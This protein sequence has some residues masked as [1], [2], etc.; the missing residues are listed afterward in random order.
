MGSPSLSSLKLWDT[1]LKPDPLEKGNLIQTI[2]GP[3]NVMVVSGLAALVESLD[4]NVRVL[5]KGT[6]TLGCLERVKEIVKPD[7]VVADQV[8]KKQVVTRDGIVVDATDIRFHYR[9]NRS[10]LGLE[11]AI[12]RRVY[13]LS[14]DA[15]GEADWGA[16]VKGAVTSPITSLIANNLL[17]YLTASGFQKNN[18][19]TPVPGRPEPRKTDPRSE[20]IKQVN[21]KGKSALTELGAELLWCDIG[22]FELPREVNAKRAET[23][24]KTWEGKMEIMRAKKEV[25][26]MRYRRAYA[27]GRTEAQIDLL[28]KIVKGLDG[29][30][31]KGPLPPNSSNIFMTGVTHLLDTLGKDA[32]DERENSAGE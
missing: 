5:E 4:G 14:L 20:I 7:E 1:S 23:W 32:L 29:L 30:S 19:A 15:K 24:Q 25:A 3:G 31:N 2:G 13:N 6:H 18:V 17:N 22:H 16:S 26:R 10:E 28:I 12:K 27:L 11:E 8:E 21:T 9:L